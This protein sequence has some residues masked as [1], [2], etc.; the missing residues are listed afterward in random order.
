MSVQFIEHNGQRQ[1]AIVPIDIYQSLLEKSEDMDDK[2]AFE[3]AKQDDDE[4]IPAEIVN[5]LLEG[6]NKLKVW[7]EYRQLTQTDLADKCGIAQSTIAQIEGGK[8]IGKINIL[9]KIADVLWL[10]LDDLA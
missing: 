10:D 7:R 6:E 4:L 1:Y 5:R 8:R 9:K 3:V 2:K